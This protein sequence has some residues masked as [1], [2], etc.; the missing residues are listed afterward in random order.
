[1]AN[2]LSNK[3]FHSTDGTTWIDFASHSG[4]RVLSIAGLD[5]IGDAVNVYTEQW[6][7]S[8][9]EDYMCTT[10][11]ID[12]GQTID[13]VVRKNVDIDLTFIVSQRYTNTH[14][15]IQQTYDDMIA[16]LCYSGA[17]YLKSTYVD[18][19]AYVVCLKAA[20][21]TAVRLQRGEYRT[22]GQRWDIGSYI[23][24]TVTF[25]CLKPP[26]KATNT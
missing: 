9:T 23:M 24:A 14:I 18:K 13:A 20:K 7:D 1:M 21:P 8:D 15:D 26:Y 19:V 4:V 17:I 12:G 25:H 10:K 11:K 6:V 16:T 2:D 22:D 5:E 3:Y